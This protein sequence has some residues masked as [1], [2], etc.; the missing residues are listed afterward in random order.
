M[1]S[2]NTNKIAPATPIT[3]PIGVTAA[4]APTSPDPSDK[5]PRVTM[6]S[7]NSISGGGGSGIGGGS[8]K[9][10]P[11]KTSG[12]AENELD[13]LLNNITHEME[14]L[15]VNTESSKICGGCGK[16]ITGACVKALG[17]QYHLDHFV[18]TNCKVQLGTLPYFE[19]DGYPYCEDHYHEL[20]SP[21]CTLCDKPITDRCLTALGHMWHPEH[22]LCAVCEKPLAEAATYY[23]R[24][25]KAFC[26]TDFY[27]TYAPKCKACNQSIVGDSV[28]ALN[29]T[30]H[31][32]HYV[33]QTCRQPFGPKGCFPVDGLPYCDKHYVDMQGASCSGCGKA[34]TGKCINALGKKYHPEHFVCAYCMK[35]LDETSFS[36][37]SNKPYCASCHNKLFS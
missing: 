36:G 28:Q 35:K 22:L 30:W 17:K 8:T 31:P 6:A 3:A 9:P 25:G 37:Q 11:S 26:E 1:N 19:K 24:D 2:M 33:C 20:F 15:G 5:K 29:T 27:Q 14:S 32:E 4:L 23:E 7:P 18:C 21:R 12:K 10:L 13:N 34:I 16:I